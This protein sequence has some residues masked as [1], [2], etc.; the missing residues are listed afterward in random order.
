M[1]DKN[2]RGPMAQ[3][4]PTARR[5]GAVLAAAACW[6]ATAAAQPAQ[7]AQLSLD[8]LGNLSLEQ[9]GNLRVTSVSRRPE[10]L[11]QAP[12]SVFVIT[13]E[14]IRRSGRVR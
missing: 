3:A 4:N 7:L 6:A 2:K 12:A 1:H 9:L 11:L 14:D 13:A 5:T 10:R 8:E